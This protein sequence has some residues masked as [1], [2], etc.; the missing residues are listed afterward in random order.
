MSTNW[1]KIDNTY[2]Q[3]VILG[4]DHYHFQKLENEEQTILIIVVVVVQDLV[5][6]QLDRQEVHL[7]LDVESHYKMNLLAHHFHYLRLQPP[8]KKII[9]LIVKNDIQGF[10]KNTQN[11]KAELL[12][13]PLIIGCIII[14]LFKLIISYVYKYITIVF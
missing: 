8:R 5:R 12:D 13:Y 6:E 14:F 9:I 10:K 3:V 7:E 2:L 11:F 4:N 1:E